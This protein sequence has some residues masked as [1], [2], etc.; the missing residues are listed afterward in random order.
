MNILHVTTHVNVG[1]ITSYLYTLGSGLRSA[2]HNVLIA[3]SGGDCVARFEQA[4]I[5][6]IRIP[7]KTKSEIDPR[8]LVSAWK[9]AKVIRQEGIQIIHSHTRVTQVLACRLSSMTHRPA[10][11]TC[12]GFFKPHFIRRM[13]P[14]WGAKTIAI[15][16]EVRQHLIDDL[17]VFER[18]I[19]VI[20][21]GVDTDRFTEVSALA[22]Q[23][24]KESFGLHDKPVVGII[25]RL[26]DVKGHI[27]LIRAMKIIAA[28]QP[29]AQLFIVGEGSQEGRLRLETGR[30]GLQAQVRFLGNVADTNDALS[31]MDIFV[32]PSLQ[33]GLG[34]GLMEA[35]AKGLP[36]VGSNVGGIKSLLCDGAH[37]ALVPP[38]DP[39]SL[40]AA[41][42]SFMQDL[43][44]A[45]A[46]GRRAREFIRQNFSEN[47]MVTATEGVYQECLKEN[48]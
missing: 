23:R 47:S 9:L 1:G 46:S 34:L 10:V 3:S 13:F 21:N 20:P 43:E 25:A 35:M 14:C 38:A 45:R 30:L 27:Y 12:H 26:S 33:E 5:R 11:T 16:P 40:A 8:I 29:E 31:A 39:D 19:R 37:G 18:D 32:M 24:A 44:G 48:G 28:R 6:C 7:I 36:V 41:I 15:S 22:R 17:G 4:G 42:A 2:G